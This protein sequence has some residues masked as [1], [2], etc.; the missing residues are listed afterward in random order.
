[1]ETR[2]TRSFL[3][4]ARPAAKKCAS[5]KR[6]ILFLSYNYVETRTAKGFKWVLNVVNR[7]DFLGAPTMIVNGWEMLY[8]PEMTERLNNSILDFQ[9]GQ[10]IVDPIGEGGR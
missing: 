4:F 7:E 2:A 9:D 3:A 6:K 8:Q 5:G 1:M 10:I